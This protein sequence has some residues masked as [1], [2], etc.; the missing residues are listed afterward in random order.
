MALTSDKLKEYLIQFSDQTFLPKLELIREF[1]EK[2]GVRIDSMQT[3]PSY[4]D[5]MN[6]DSAIFMIKNF[7]KNVEVDEF[8]MGTC[9]VEIIEAFWIQEGRLVSKKWE[10]Q[11]DSDRFK[12]IKIQIIE[13]G[14]VNILT[15]VQKRDI[16]IISLLRK[17]GYDTLT[18]C[19]S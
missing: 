5:P 15:R 12:P 3:L 16:P 13:D 11:R 7:I 6:V 19:L 14:M 1:D 9:R 18:A 8:F 17:F 2:Y 10:V 4:I